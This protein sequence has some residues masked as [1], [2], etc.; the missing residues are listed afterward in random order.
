MKYLWLCWRN[1]KRHPLRNALTVGALA[2]ALFCFALLRSLLAAFYAPT[3]APA[4]ARRLWI[5]SAVSLAQPLPVGI[6]PKLAGVEGIETLAKVSWFGGVYKNDPKLF[7]ANFAVD[8]G[9]L[10][11]IWTEYQFPPDALAGFKAKKTAALIGPGLLKEQYGMK[12]GDTITLTG[13]Y[14]P[15]NPELQIVG[16]YGMAAKGVP[17]NTLFFHHDYFADLQPEFGRVGTFVVIATPTANPGDVGKRIDALTRNTPAETK[18]ET[19]REFQRGFIEMMGNLA[20]II[21]SIV[22]AILVA[23]LFVAATTVA[24]SARERVSEIAVLKTLGFSAGAILGLILTEALLL[25]F[26]AAFAGLGLAAFLMKELREHDTS[27][28]FIGLEMR[29]PVMLMTIG[30]GALIGAIAGGLPAWSA[31]RTKIVDGLR[32]LN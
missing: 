11:K 29:W 14:Y 15:V 18:S 16:V 17:D 24:M 6:E 21:N 26:T 9:K 3:A 27:G 10:E 32:V 2:I 13:T 7:F 23:M 8:A 12:V 5:R 19:E 28:F 1:L 25:A 4:T 20:L 30:A 31:S 22:S